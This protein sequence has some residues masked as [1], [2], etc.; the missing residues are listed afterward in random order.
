MSNYSTRDYSMFIY[1][2][3]IRFNCPHSQLMYSFVLR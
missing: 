3:N 1:K 2:K